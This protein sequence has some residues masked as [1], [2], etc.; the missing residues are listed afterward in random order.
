MDISALITLQ[1]RFDGLSQTVPGEDIEFWYARDLMEPLGYVRWEN[2]QTAIKRVITSCETTGC[3]PNDHFQG[4]TKMV[5]LGSGVGP[6][7]FYAPTH[8]Q[9]KPTNNS[10]ILTSDT[11]NSVPPVSDHIWRPIALRNSNEIS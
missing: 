2:F 9:K 8:L 6:Y 3:E 5:K 7:K 11:S 4:V 10:I 1:N